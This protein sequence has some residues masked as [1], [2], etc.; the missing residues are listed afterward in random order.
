MWNMY[1]Y[2]RERWR[3]KVYIDELFQAENFFFAM[4]TNVLS[5]A[6]LI[7][8]D[9]FLSNSV[10]NVPYT[11]LWTELEGKN[12][13]YH[14]DYEYDNDKK[15]DSKSVLECKRKRCLL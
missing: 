8:S 4:H 5:Y 13:W 11:E 15:Q 6:S 3:R 1:V 12:C 14:Y 10:L 7:E 2:A 9:P